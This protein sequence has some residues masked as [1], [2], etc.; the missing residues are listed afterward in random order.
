MTPTHYDNAY[1]EI[2]SVRTYSEYVFD[3]T[4]HIQSVVGRR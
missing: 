4:T 1:F 2:V 3:L